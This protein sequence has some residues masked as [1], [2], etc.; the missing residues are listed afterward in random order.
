VP[1]TPSNAPDTDPGKLF[2]L[3]ARPYGTAQI[4]R[5][6]TGRSC[7]S[8]RLERLEREAISMPRLEVK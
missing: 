1:S 7:K 5:A 2:G 6:L 8:E 3:P 4:R